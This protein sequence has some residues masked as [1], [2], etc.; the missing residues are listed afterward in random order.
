MARSFVGLRS[1]AASFAMLCAVVTTCVPAAALRLRVRAR[2]TATVQAH[3]V[4][5]GA[6]I[7]GQLHD[8]RG[9]PVAG[10]AVQLSVQR[11]QRGAADDD[12]RVGPPETMTAQTSM[13]GMFEGRVAQLAGDHDL[14][15]TARFAGTPQF[16]ATQI[17]RR[18]APG[19]LQPKLEVQVKPALLTTDVEALDV[20]VFVGGPLEPLD[21]RVVK[22][23]V[24]G[25]LRAALRTGPDGWATW[26]PATSALMPLGAHEISFEA[27]ETASENA[28]FGR[29][30]VELHR[31]TVV[32]LRATE[33]IAGK[34]CGARQVCLAGEVAGVEPGGRLVP[35]AAATVSLHANRGR[36][37]DTV[38]DD[39][40]RFAV[41]LDGD[42]LR[43]AL[44][45]GDIGVVARAQLPEPFSEPG[46]S[47][48]VALRAPLPQTISQW[49]YAALL[50]L[51]AGWLVWRRIADRM[52][53][54]TLA[55]E[56]E[57]LAAG[58]P[59]ATVR[60][61]GSGGLRQRTVRG[62]VMHGETGRPARATVTVTSADG[63]A[64][65]SA[66]CPDGL[67][68]LSEMQDGAWTLQVT[69]DEHEPLTLQV[70]IPH[71]GTFDGC[72]LLPR[73]N[74]ALVRGAY[75]GA[76]RRA[77]DRPMDWRHETPK[78]AEVRWITA[79]RRGHALI[80][81]AV[82]AVD[83]AVYGRPTGLDQVRAATEAL[84]AAKEQR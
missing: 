18:L 75:A 8:V 60:R 2:A 28:A 22:V 45:T 3:R 12:E 14:R 11:V 44:G 27:P 64:V 16:A 36:L 48:I 57:D 67:V 77:S 50:A 56:L 53:Q 58:L 33:S 70:V 65:Q 82:R 80:R 51:M 19:K 32:A 5:G 68:L 15:V 34:A 30:A 59:T 10:V 72:E 52:R 13:R 4:S 43:R 76:I 7:R 47:P 37:I 6:I 31:A 21:D 41:R 42:V 66:D 83:R 29:A 23:Q 35:A 9:R 55:R 63:A 1:G 73:S 61:A 38:A 79:S 24:D 69:V 84:D 74:R 71:D 26:R 17:A 81:A 78:M 54:R 39:A 20:A 40:G 62:V 25:Q 46:W 49:L